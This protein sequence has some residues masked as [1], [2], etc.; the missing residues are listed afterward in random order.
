EFEAATRG[1]TFTRGVGLP[2]RVWDSAAPTWVPDVV[3]DPNFPRASVARREGLHGAFALPLLIQGQ[4]VGVMEF[5]SREIREP[6]DDLLGMLTRVGAQIGLFMERKRDA[7]ELDRFFNLSLDML[8]VAGFDGY[9]KRLN[10][11][12][13]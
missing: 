12:W 5:F 3:S 13:E 10:P 9:F 7:E 1:T 6:D 11:A 4:V 2:G 8:C